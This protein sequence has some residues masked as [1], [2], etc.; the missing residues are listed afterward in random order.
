MGW[1]G[2]GVGQRLARPGATHGLDW[3]AVMPADRSRAHGA[4]PVLAQIAVA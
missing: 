3:R 2:V 1:V 4:A